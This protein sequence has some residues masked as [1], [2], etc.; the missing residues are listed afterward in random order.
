M[1]QALY[2][3]LSPAVAPVLV[4]DDAPAEA[5]F[6]YITLGEA[7]SDQGGDKSQDGERVTV[8][9]HAWSRKSGRRE[10]KELAAKVRAALHNTTLTVAGADPVQLRYE[11][12]TDFL[13]PETMT[14]HAVIR[15]GADITLT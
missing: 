1:Q 9:L 5:A 10:V 4:Y 8:T 2:A 12:S 11:F 6:P 3:A 13:E 14:K 15:F 7:T